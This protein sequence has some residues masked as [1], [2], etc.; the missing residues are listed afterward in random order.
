MI[1][2]KIPSISQVKTTTE[3]TYAM[4]ATQSQKHAPVH[5]TYWLYSEGGGKLGPFTKSEARAIVAA[6]PQV[7]FRARRDGEVEWKD[8]AVRLAPKKSRGWL[9]I[10]AFAVVAISALGAWWSA[11]QHHRSPRET[12][13]N[14][15]PTDVQPSEAPT[16]SA[17]GNPDGSAVGAGTGPIA[18]VPH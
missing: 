15:Q 4:N 5:H 13:A 1:G 2:R 9:W 11:N 16:T 8:A 12:A 3:R 10:I 14:L 6:S 7:C 18:N 17:E